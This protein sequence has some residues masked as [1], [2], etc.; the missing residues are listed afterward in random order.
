MTEIAAVITAEQ[1]VDW[2]LKRLES[3][4]PQSPRTLSD[5]LT[6]ARLFDPYKRFLALKLL[7]A[8]LRPPLGVYSHLTQQK[9]WAYDRERWAKDA[10]LRRGKVELEF[11]PETEKTRALIEAMDASE[12]LPDTARDAITSISSV[13]SRRAN[14]KLDET[15]AELIGDGVQELMHEVE[16]M[17]RLMDEKD[18]RIKQAE[19][20]ADDLRRTNERMLAIMEQLTGKAVDDALVP[21]RDR[22]EKE[23]SGTRQRTN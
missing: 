5:W 10:G 20:H 8:R 11:D 21:S 17:G 14:R 22:E 1:A 7:R 18:A 19:R 23:K 12:R 3:A 6:E 9:R 16:V 4:D 13:L 2:V 15:S